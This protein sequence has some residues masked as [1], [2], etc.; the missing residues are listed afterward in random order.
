MPE[1]TYMANFEFVPE[2]TSET[3]MFK[4]W[5]ERAGVVINPMFI[6]IEDQPVRFQTSQVSVFPK[7]RSPFWAR[8]R[9]SSTLSSIHLI[10]GPEK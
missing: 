9:R 2:A 7:S 8:A 1:I 10:F 4:E 5:G 6:L 3:M